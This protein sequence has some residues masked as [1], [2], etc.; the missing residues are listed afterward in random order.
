MNIATLMTCSI[1]QTITAIIASALC[2]CVCLCV[3][4]NT[5]FTSK[6]RT[7]LEVRTKQVLGL[8]LKLA[9]E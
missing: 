8:R 9:F 5:N 1:G 3:H 2:V 6:V 4:Q 7:F